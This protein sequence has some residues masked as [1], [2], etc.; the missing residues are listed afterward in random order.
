MHSGPIHSA[1][2]HSGPEGD[3]CAAAGGV[4]LGPAYLPP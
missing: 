4:S 1:H 2:M 3:F